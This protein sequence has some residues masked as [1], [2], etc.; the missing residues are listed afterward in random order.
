MSN[1]LRSDKRTKN[2]F[3]TLIACLSFAFLILNSSKTQIITE[4]IKK[5]LLPRNLAENSGD[6]GKTK[7]CEK[8]SSKFSQY[9]KTRDKSILGLEEDNTEN[10]SS[11]HVQAL[12]NIVKHYYKKKESKQTSSRILDEEETEYKK[13][14]FKYIYHILPLVIVLG[15]GILSLPG[16]AVCCCCICCKCRYCVCNRSKCKTPSIVLALIFY[17]IVAL[18]SFYSLVEKNKVFSGI[19]DIEC[20]VLRFTDEVLYGETSVYPPYW[21][22]IDHLKETLTCMGG[23][24]T[25]LNTGSTNDE[26]TYH[27][28]TIYKD[29]SN[30]NDYG[31]KKT[32]E[33][34]LKNAG[35]TISNQYKYTMDDNKE[36][37]LDIAKLFGYYDDAI[38]KIVPEKSVYNFWL[39]EY[40]SAA[41]KAKTE[42]SETITNLNS[43]FSNGNNILT[44]NQKLDEIKEEFMSLKNLISDK[45]VEKA[46]EIDK[47]GRLVYTLF[48]YLLMIFCAAI[49]VFMLLLCCCSGKVCTDLSCFQCFFKIFIHIFWNLMAI[50]MF[51][52]FM[53][54]SLFTISGTIGDDLVNVVSYLISEDNLG[55]NSDT[56]ILGNVKQYLN[57]CFNDDGSILEELGFDSSDT[58][59]LESLKKS[60]ADIEELRNQFMDKWN[61]F[62]YTEYKEELNKR[63]KYTSEDL[64]LIE[65]NDDEP[66]EITFQSL[67][68]K[69]NKYADDNGMNE[70]WNITSTSSAGCYDGKP[71]QKVTYHPYYCFPTAKSWVGT[72]LSNEY[73][74][75][76]KIK[77]FIDKANSDTD[78]ASIKNI[79][80]NL[81]VDYQ[82]FLDS[83]IDTLEIFKEKIHKLTE[84]TEQ[85]A[86]D[87]DEL[88]SFM[89]CNFVKDNVDVILFYLK[90][91]FQ[92]DLY[93][94][95]VYL[96]I[97]AFSMPFA[98]SFTILLIMISN[99]DIQTNKKKI[100]EEKRRKS[101]KG[102]SLLLPP[103]AQK[104]QN[105]D[106]NEGN[107]GDEGNNTEQRGLNNKV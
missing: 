63:V 58:G 101:L 100:A 79:I 31:K 48:F 11:K 37:Q 85:Y 49:V 39:N 89:N 70:N 59:M 75:L 32:F 98:I 13:N 1:I 41:E 64:S 42:M 53:G 94:V 12:I 102:N 9:Y 86:S 51:V 46:D 26:L 54:G 96:L 92:N 20:A 84:P 44:V 45:I 47:T 88:F 55:T 35:D 56:I 69:V 36:Y 5:N 16:W 99:E 8:T 24:I 93:E 72:Y 77:D 104:V 25:A 65:S 68:D 33:N 28:N 23:N 62:V 87:D 19:A 52:L 3:L 22:G 57:K 4:K 21:A 73:T 107:E 10:Y 103:P 14:V 80:T 6:T 60:K 50:V 29:D 43:V 97:A 66:S 61:K 30:L 106:L 7:I 76:G 91:S 34:S 17:I 71:A 2:I 15:I 82:S 67:L 27:Y 81:N 40:S 18:I 74:Q 95:G 83:E 78:A 90:N 105:N 38:K